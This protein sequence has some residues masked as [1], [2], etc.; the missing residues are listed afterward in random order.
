MMPIRL[1]DAEL[2]ELMQAAQTVP[3]DLRRTFLERVAA[4]LR[5]KVRAMA[6][7]TASLTRSPARSFGT[8]G[9]DLRDGGVDLIQRDF[10]AALV[11]LVVRV[12]RRTLGHFP[13]RNT[14][15]FSLQ[16]VPSDHSDKIL[17][18]TL[19]EFVRVFLAGAGDHGGASGPSRTPNQALA[20]GMTAGS[21]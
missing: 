8:R 3:Y 19:K 2:R 4:A 17:K 9:G 5:D 13:Y 7:C 14:R 1:S 6:W 11:L 15:T 18:R 10:L 20:S 21:K 16:D 12:K